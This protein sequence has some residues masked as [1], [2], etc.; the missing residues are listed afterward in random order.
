MSATEPTP[1]DGLD[2]L[3]SRFR[4]RAAGWWRVVGDR[5]EQVAFSASDEMPDDVA[6]GF[7]GA[8][9]SVS[10]GQSDLGIVRAV[11]SGEP[12][13]SRASELPA[14]TGSGLWLRRFGALRSIAVPL[15]DGSGAV[16]GIVSLALAEELPEDA[17]V[18]KAIQAE[19]EGWSRG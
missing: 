18:A 9:R 1:Q 3:R 8:T 4:A 10:M 13:V 5:L 12:T 6:R 17:D 16:V 15:R 7:A 14:E 19:A 2:A 11:A